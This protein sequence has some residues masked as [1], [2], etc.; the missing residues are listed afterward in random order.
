MS[1]GFLANLREGVMGGGALQSGL[2]SGAFPLLF[3]QGPLGQTLNDLF[4][5]LNNVKYFS[6]IDATSCYHNLK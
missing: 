6:L 5:K 4:P 1:Q 2:V 3:G